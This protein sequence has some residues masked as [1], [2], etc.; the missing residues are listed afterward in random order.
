MLMH[1]YAR[2][3]TASSTICYVTRQRIHGKYGRRSS[4]WVLCYVNQWFPNQG[5]CALLVMFHGGAGRK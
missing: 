2:Q 3:T 1:T 5:A 4:R